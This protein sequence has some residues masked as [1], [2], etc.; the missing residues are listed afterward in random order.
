MIAVGNHIPLML[1]F[2]CVSLKDFMLKVAPSDTIGGAISLV[3][4][5]I[6]SFQNF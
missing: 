4:L 5:M 6:P 3:G 1:I 2:P